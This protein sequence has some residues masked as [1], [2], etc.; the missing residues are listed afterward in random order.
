ML[1]TIPAFAA[2]SSKAAIISHLATLQN[3]DVTSAAQGGRPGDDFLY[4]LAGNDFLFGGSGTDSYD[5]GTDIDHLEIANEGGAGETGTLTGFGIVVEEIN[6]TTYQI[7][8]LWGDVDTVTNVEVIRGSE[9]ADQF[10]SGIADDTFEGRGGDDLFVF[11]NGGGDDT[12]LDFSDVAGNDDVLDFTGFGAALD[13][14]ILLTGTN[15]AGSNVVIDLGVDGSITL[16]GVQ[17]V[18]FDAGDFLFS[19]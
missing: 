3:I 14:G 9:L 8:D 10:I 15:D 1:Q 6:L 2:K 19:A 4:G 13:L 16:I 17:K 5:G 12:L 11:S 18:N 7:D